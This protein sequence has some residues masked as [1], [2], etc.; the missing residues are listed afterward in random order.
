MIFVDYL[1]IGGSNSSF[2]TSKE[3]YLV[4]LQSGQSCL[5]SELP[6]ELSQALVHTFRRRLL[7]CSSM[8]SSATG[9]LKCFIWSQNNGWERFATP[10]GNSIDGITKSVSVPNVGVWFFNGDGDS[11]LLNENTGDWETPEFSWTT[12]R[13]ASCAVQ[14]SNTVTANIGGDISTSV[15][16]VFVILIVEL[17]ALE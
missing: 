3:V 5:H 2:T 8:T 9:T 15:G 13:N 7:A 4:N 1:S 16:S 12:I 11:L 17:K 14:I 10:D 6:E